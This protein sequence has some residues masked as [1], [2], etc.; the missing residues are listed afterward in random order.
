M[1]KQTTTHPTV[2]GFLLCKTFFLQ[3][4]LIWRLWDQGTCSF[5]PS[6]LFSSQLSG[7]HFKREKRRES[8]ILLGTTVNCSGVKIGPGTS[9]LFFPF[10]KKGTIVQFLPVY[11]LLSALL[12]LLTPN[13]TFHKFYKYLKD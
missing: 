3:R 6:T 8:S 5:P 10:C 7:G 9:Y 4:G 12:L 1:S 13:C 2:Q 11:V